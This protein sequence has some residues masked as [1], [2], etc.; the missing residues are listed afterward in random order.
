M[1]WVLVVV[2][3]FELESLYQLDLIMLPM[4]VMMAAYLRLLPRLLSVLSVDPGKVLPMV[5]ILSSQVY[6]VRVDA[7]FAVVLAVVSVSPSAR[8]SDWV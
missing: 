3:A 2:A 7:A 4:L 6:L 1:L 8:V 5:R